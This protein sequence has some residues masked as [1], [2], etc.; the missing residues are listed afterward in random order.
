MECTYIFLLTQ[1]W[2]CIYP[3]YIAEGQSQQRQM[4]VF[5]SA[6]CKLMTPRHLWQIV[7]S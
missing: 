6:C 4:S 3:H 1:Q 2:I 5:F 7:S